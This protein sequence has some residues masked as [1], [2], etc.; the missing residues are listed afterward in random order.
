MIKEL[1]VVH[2]KKKKGILKMGKKNKQKASFDFDLMDA[3]T[4][5]ECT[6][7]TPRPPLNDSEYESY[8]EVFNFGPPKVRN[9][10]D[11]K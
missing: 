4:S 7:I 9:K 3:S 11:K 1:F 6:G 5:T 10:K 8:Q 2:N